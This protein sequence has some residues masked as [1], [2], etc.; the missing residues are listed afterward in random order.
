MYSETVTVVVINN[1]TILK[2]T[3]QV[4]KICVTSFHIC[5][6]FLKSQKPIKQTTLDQYVQVVR[7]I[8]AGNGNEPMRS[9]TTMTD[10]PV[11]LPSARNLAG[12]PSGDSR[13]I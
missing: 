7:F 9:I 6:R 12:K 8:T 3:K 10:R 13:Q 11:L 4:N 5:C 1:Y 2:H